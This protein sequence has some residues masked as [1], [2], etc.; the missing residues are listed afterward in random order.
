MRKINLFIVF[1]LLLFL[2]G[3]QK[4][5]YTGENTGTTCGNITMGA[6]KFAYGN[7]FIYISSPG[8]IYEYDLS[9][10]VP[11]ILE[12]PGS[13]YAESMFLSEQ[14]VYYSNGSSLKKLQ[15][16][17][18]KNDVVIGKTSCRKF[19]ADGMDAYFMNHI[20]GDL[21]HIDMQT[22]KETTLLSVVNNY[23]V[24][25]TSIYAV[26]KPDGEWKLYHSSRETINFEPIKLSFQPV[27]VYV[28]G[29]DI[30]LAK[31]GDFQLIQYTD[32]VETP[33]PCHSFFYQVMDGSLI[34]MD[35]QTNEGGCFLL[36]SYDLTTGEGQLLCENVYD[37]CILEDRYICCQCANPGEATF[38]LIDTQTN[39]MTQMYPTEE[40]E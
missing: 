2:S 26:A 19:F 16:D 35:D 12:T 11:I 1:L 31:Q 33:L 28:D 4:T 17:G 18:K 9:T 23:Y 40:E 25:D 13:D 3:C 38:I 37:F 32:G 24:D 21:F 10:G 14:D 20:E 27:A 5:A 15:K 30:F 6:G 22:K 8:E 29:E 36:K 34:Y 7:G 39:E